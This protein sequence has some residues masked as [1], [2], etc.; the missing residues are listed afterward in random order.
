MK[1]R[2]GFV[3]NSS[4]SSFIINLNDITA[5]Q[6]YA[7]ENHIE[8]A[9]KMGMWA[10]GS[11][12]WDIFINYEDGYIKGFTIMDN[13]DMREFLKKIGVCMVEWNDMS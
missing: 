12:R 8:V 13:F 2:N 4:S 9:N 6:S 1:I 7:I 11:D 3:S 5:L 10:S